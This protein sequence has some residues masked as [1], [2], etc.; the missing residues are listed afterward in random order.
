MQRSRDPGRWRVNASHAASR[1]LIRH[2]RPLD[3]GS[4]P[5]AGLTV[6]GCSS[7]HF[8]TVPASFN[9]KTRVVPL[10]SSETSPSTNN[11]IG[12]GAPSR[13]RTVSES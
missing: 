13:L 6:M 8:F 3:T 4:E 5:S 12:G 10:T 9:R 2:E 11:V 1:I 7:C